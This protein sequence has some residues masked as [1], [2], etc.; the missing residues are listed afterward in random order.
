LSTFST[1]GFLKTFVG[2]GKYKRLFQ[3]RNF[4][5][6]L[7]NIFIIFV[8]QIPIMLFFA[9]IFAFLLNDPKLKL[10]S[11]LEQHYFCLQ[12]RLCLLILYYLK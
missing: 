5:L 3:G 12:Q 2:F 10:K 6:S 7:K 4:L 11:F 8:V 9:L 1:G